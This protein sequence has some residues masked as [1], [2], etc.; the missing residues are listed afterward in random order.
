MGNGYF[1]NTRK[2]ILMKF[3]AVIENLAKVFWKLLKES[4]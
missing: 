4:W 2:E 1:A 3:P